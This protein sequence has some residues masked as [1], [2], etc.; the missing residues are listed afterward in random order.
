MFLVKKNHK[1]VYGCGLAFSLAFLTKSWHA[2]MIMAVGGIYLLGTGEL[3]RFRKKEWAGFL[4]SVFCATDAVVW[5]AL[6]QGRLF[7]PEEYGR[8]RFA[9][10]DRKLEF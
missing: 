3:R 6:Y 4:L 5:L 7:L 8:D 10:T 2:G 9:G 1:Y